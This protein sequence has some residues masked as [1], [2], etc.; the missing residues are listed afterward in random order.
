MKAS[1]CKC[2]F[3][4]VESYF[5]TFL[6]RLKAQDPNNNEFILCFY[7]VCYVD[8]YVVAL[9]NMLQQAIQDR[10]KCKTAGNARQLNI[11]ITL[12]LNPTDKDILRLIKKSL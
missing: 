1:A 2:F 7:F 3:I 5:M 8:L 9:N 11:Y 12:H 10:R 4:L 6:S